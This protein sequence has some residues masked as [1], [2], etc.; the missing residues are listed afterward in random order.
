MNADDHPKGHGEL[1]HDTAAIIG[2]TLDL[3]EKVVSDAMTS[4]DNVSNA[5]TRLFSRTRTLN[6]TSP[7]I[8][9]HVVYR[10]SV[11]LR[12]TYKDS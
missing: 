9:V 12:Y 7:V 4:I 8:G 3:Q 10:F 2:H 6:V 5:Y 11:G 1:K